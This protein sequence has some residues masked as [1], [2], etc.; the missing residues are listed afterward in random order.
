MRAVW[1]VLLFFCGGLSVWA[2]D[3]AARQNL[4]GLLVACHDG[5]EQTVRELLCKDV[6]LARQVL[7][8]DQQRQALS[9]LGIAVCGGYV[10]IVG[11]L[12]EAGTDVN[13]RFGMADITPLMQLCAQDH[14]GSD[15]LPTTQVRA[16]SLS[17]Q[18][19][20]T[21]QAQSPHSAL[22]VGTREHLRCLRMLLDSGADIDACDNQGRSALYHCAQW[23]NSEALAVL[24]RHGA[25]VRGWSHCKQDPLCVASLKGHLSC[26][27]ALLAAGCPV[28]SG[29]QHGFSALNC[30]AQGGHV[31]IVKYLFQQGASVN[32]E[33]TPTGGTPLLVAAEYGQLACM[34]A[35]LDGGV[36]I[37]GAN[38]IGITALYLAAQ[39][40]RLAALKM[41][42]SR[43]AQI[44]GWSSDDSDPLCAAAFYGRLS[45]VRALV[46]AGAAIVTGRKY[47]FSALNNAA[48]YGHVEVLQYLLQQGV[49]VNAESSVAG[50]TP[51]LVA[52]K[53]GQLACMQ[54]L[55]DAGAEIDRT[56]CVGRTSL[57]CA[58]Q[59]GQLAALKM[60][61]SRGAKIKGWSSCE[62]DPLC[63]AALRGHMASVRALVR[64]G[65]PIITARRYG[66]SALNNAAQNG[67]M[68]ILEYLLQ[69]GV[70]ANAESTPSG[71]TPLRVAS[72][73]GHILCMKVLLD[74]GADLNHSLNGRTALYGAAHENRLAALALLLAS[75][76]NRQGWNDWDSD[77]LCIAAFNGHVECV[78]ALVMAGSP[79]VTGRK[80]TFSALH[81]A[82]YN[83]HVEILE[84][85]LQQ[86]VSASVESSPNGGTPLMAA[87][88]SGHLWCIRTL[89]AAGAAVNQSTDYGKTALYFAAVRGQPEAVTLLLAG[90]ADVDHC[91][92]AHKTA[93][94]AACDQGHERVVARLLAAGANPRT[95]VQDVTALCRAIQRGYP[96][97]VEQLLAAG[98][99]PLQSPDL[100]LSLVLPKP[101]VSEQKP[102][103]DSVSKEDEEHYA[104][105]DI[106]RLLQQTGMALHCRHG[107]VRCE[108]KSASCRL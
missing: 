79:I 68:E 70:S 92:R 55:L 16:L 66:F 19:T 18:P 26:V 85:L 27:R 89:L 10:G 7:A 32:A 100:S 30:A 94:W 74:A 97:V 99:N 14:D 17:I 84:Y 88:E 90:G 78:K 61:L 106:T 5:D 105:I 12:I 87:S 37:N 42:L 45:C 71:G 64:A 33:S 22:S 52:A 96:K 46:T 1:C 47:G 34:Q 58:A 56:N 4:M 24:V 44:K 86:G 29:R 54:I 75:G 57:Y 53:E 91:S 38:S 80:Y 102:R 36:D 83:G 25:R 103:V 9:P 31:E 20:T 23:G 98:L 65:A 107:S 2:G 49:S 3:N 72:E 95:S 69:Q 43:G 59:E 51:L 108:Q 104:E 21:V 11:L 76:A 6:S 48:Q 35:L 63:I 28:V 81:A 62:S 40:G 101:D 67:H 82:V 13:G 50:G 15:E 93:L 60:L 39:E 73:K 41:L 8:V 77:P